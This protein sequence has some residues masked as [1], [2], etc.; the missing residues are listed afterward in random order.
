MADCIC[1]FPRRFYKNLSMAPEIFLDLSPCV[2]NMGHSK[3]EKAANN[4][5][6]FS[7]VTLRE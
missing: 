2:A 3:E 5:D 1:Y 4:A 7:L 6:H